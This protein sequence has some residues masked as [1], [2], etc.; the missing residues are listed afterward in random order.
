[1]AM[2]AWL[3]KGFEQLNLFVREG[4]HL[5]PSDYDYTDRSALSQHRRAKKCTHA[6]TRAFA[7]GIIRVHILKIVNMYGLAIKDHSTRGICRTDRPKLRSWEIPE[8]SY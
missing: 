8:G 3:A 4:P 1:M 6:S 2:T 5:C 7:I